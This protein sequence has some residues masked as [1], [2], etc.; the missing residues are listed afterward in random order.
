MQLIAPKVRG[1]TGENTQDR[2]LR[3]LQRRFR[4]TEK[5]V[6]EQKHGATAHSPQKVPVWFQ[7][8]LT[9]PTELIVLDTN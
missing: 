7:Q 1:T 5:H 8:A 6:I 9:V 4:S 3:C 2:R